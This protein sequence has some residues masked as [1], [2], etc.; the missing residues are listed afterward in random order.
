MAS[1]DGAEVTGITVDR[2]SMEL[3][4]AFDDGTSGTIGLV[5]LRLHCPCATCRARR[6]AGE[7]AWPPPGGDGRL[8]LSDAQLVGAW[9]LGV[10]WADGHSTGIYPFTALHEWILAGHPVL[11]ADSGLGA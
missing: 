10:T 9:G 7:E 6:Q 3:R 8:E 11:R 5:E 4:L 1:M 2:E